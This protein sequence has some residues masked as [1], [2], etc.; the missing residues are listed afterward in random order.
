[1]IDWIHAGPSVT[2][3]FLGSLVECVEAVTIVLAVGTVRGWREALLGAAGGLAVLTVLVVGLGPALAVIPLTVLQLVIGVLLLLFGLS[4]LRKAVLRAAG[5]IPLHFKAV[6]LEGLEVVF[7]VLAVGAAGHMIV[8]ASLGAVGAAI[9]VALAALA[10]RGPLTRVPENTL[11]LSVGVLIGSFG[12]FWIGEGLGF[13]WPGADL[14]VLGLAVAFL[15]ASL[16]ATAVLRRS[17]GDGAAGRPV[18][19]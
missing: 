11:K 10:L 8:P 1:M 7:I 5:I 14:A 12:A 2:T 15:A 18:I 16:L 4:W 6:V 3:A 17:R 19:S 9:V 13:H